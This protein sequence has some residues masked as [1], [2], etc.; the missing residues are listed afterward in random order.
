M[1]VSSYL[2]TFDTADVKIGAERNPLKTEV[3]YFSP[4]L[5]AAPPVSRVTDVCLLASVSRAACGSNTLGVTVEPRQFIADSLLAKKE[6]ADVIRAMHE[7]VQLC[8]DPR[9]EFALLRESL[10]VSRMNHIL[11]VHGHT[12]LQERDKG[13]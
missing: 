6:Q 7:C 1:L 2:Q 9:A 8:Q 5:A 13:P 4:N 3:I 12:I 10:G 11:R